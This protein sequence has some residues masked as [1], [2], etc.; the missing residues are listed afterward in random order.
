MLEANEDMTFWLL[1]IQMVREEMFEIAKLKGLRAE[2]TVAISQQLDRLLNE[3]YY[4][5]QQE[6][7]TSRVPDKY[8]TYV[9]N[10]SGPTHSTVNEYLMQI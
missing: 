1:R 3:F 9:Y 2:E 8:S 4:T 5:F 7:D 10:Q 6:Q